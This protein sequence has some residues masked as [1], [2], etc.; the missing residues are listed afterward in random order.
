[1]GT[2]NVRVS[3]YTFQDRGGVSD[4]VHPTTAHED[5]EGEKR[6]SSSLS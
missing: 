1:M 4:E 2:R 5:P 3:L 6:Y